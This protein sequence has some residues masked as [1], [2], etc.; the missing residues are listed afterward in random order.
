LGTAGTRGTRR[1]IVALYQTASTPT[2]RCNMATTYTTRTADANDVRVMAGCND[3]LLAVGRIALAVIFL[4]SGFQKFTDLSGV[5]AMLG[6]KGLPAPYVLAALSAAVELGG[7]VLIVVGWQTRIAALALGLF[8]L[9][10]AYFFHDFWHMPPGA[11]HTDNMI[12]AMKNLSMFGGF[13]ILAA[14][15]AGRYSIDGPCRVHVAP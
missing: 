4:M 11:E 14:V 6:S 12:H 7:G 8:S 15:G 9:V 5:A 10:A 2:D 3:A 13:L 1:D